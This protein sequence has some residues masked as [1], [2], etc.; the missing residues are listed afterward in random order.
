MVYFQHILILNKK[1]ELPFTPSD[2]QIIKSILTV[3]Q[4]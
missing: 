4:S 3:V 1:V 2:K